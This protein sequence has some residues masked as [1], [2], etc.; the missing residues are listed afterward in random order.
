MLSVL[1]DALSCGWLLI[2]RHS[3]GENRRSCA[4]VLV[5]FVVDR[6][7]TAIS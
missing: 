7:C 1:E 4:L 2:K 3:M 6:S 5:E